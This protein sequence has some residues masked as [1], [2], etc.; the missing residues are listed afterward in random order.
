MDQLV[1]NMCDI[2]KPLVSM[3]YIAKK[4]ASQRNGTQPSNNHLW[5]R[6]EISVQMSYPKG[7]FISFKAWLRLHNFQHYE[8]FKDLKD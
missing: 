5:N 8:N 4:I 3:L 1:S 2:M 6:Y 7:T